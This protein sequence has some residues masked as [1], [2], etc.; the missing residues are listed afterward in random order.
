MTAQRIAIRTWQKFFYVKIL[1]KMLA[2]IKICY[3]FKQERRSRT[4]G[5]GRS[6][7]I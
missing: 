1:I 6:P 7:F 2:S 4:L 3:I 5:R